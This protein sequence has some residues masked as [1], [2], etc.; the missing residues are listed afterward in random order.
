MG[1]I[2]KQALRSTIINFIGAT[3]G[4]LTRVIMP[5]FI[6]PAQLGLLTLLD[7]ISGAFVT[8]F[9]MGYD[10]VLIKLFPKY[11]NEENGHHGFLLFG[12][13][14]S[15]VGI[16][17]SFILF[18]LFGDYFLK[19]DSDIE[20]YHRFSFLIFPLIFFRIIFYNIDGYARM[21]FNTFIGVFLETFLSKV[22]I[23][24]A[25]AAFALAW[26]EFDQLV[27]LYALSFCVP[28][29]LVMLFAL[30]KT[31]KIVLPRREIFEKAQRKDI[32]QYI[33]FGLLMGASGSI[34]IYIDGL[35]IGKMLSL[36][37]VAFYTIF[38]FAARFILI[39]GRAINRIA[40]VILAEAWQKNDSETIR[41]VYQKSCV[42]QLLIGAF[43]LGVGWTC[44]DPA[45]SLSPKFAEYAP[46]KSV[47]LILGLGLLI[48]MATGV[49]TAIIATSKKYK[50]N[51]WFN[52]AL[53][54]L[55]IVLNYILIIKYQLF[56]AA[57]ASMIAMGV[58][59]LMRWYFLYRTYQLQPFNF[60]FLKGLVLA[61]AFLLFCYFFSYDA[62][63]LLKIVL[64]LF[65]LTI[66]FWGLVV[67]L[68]LSVDVNKWLL[69]MKQKFF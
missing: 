16:T 6:T 29:F 1:I 25:L 37:E 22:V 33:L 68:K 30:K 32:Y 58:I 18:Y 38:F 4:G 54:V 7:F 3:F 50:Y 11:R 48:E 19:E 46:Y 44:L 66:I 15:L 56:G 53:A 47:F 13:F 28:G 61:V 41:D 65:A 51:T 31:K 20:L 43:L 10:Q 64:N 14:L 23:I 2:Q 69:K 17:I 62:N 59:N 39:P 52:I 34:V 45:L 36:E 49:N 35:M 8:I 55:V 40:A 60:N 9:G 5:L 57:I 12:F 63:P 27:Y 21:L 26:I 24:S 42:N 67:G